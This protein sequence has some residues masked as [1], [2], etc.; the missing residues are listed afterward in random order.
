MGEQVEAIIRQINQEN[1]I[2]NKAR[3]MRYLIK[4]HQLRVI[5]LEKKLNLKSS[6]ICHLLRLNDLPPL[7]IDGYYSG[8]ISLSH[9]FVLSRLKDKK[10]LISL[11]EKVLSDNL[12]VVQTEEELREIIYQIKTKGE[13]LKKEKIEK[14]TNELKKIF[15]NLKIKLI[16]T[17]I[18]GKLI[19]EVK[20][21]LEGSS[22]VINWLIDK[23][24]K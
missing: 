13:Y 5:D 20:D 10:K 14:L 15:P 2:F 22:K 24:T 4:E 17:R 11:Y 7:V 23:L 16:Q 12:T 6:Y 21:N 19:F 8:L 9:L 18:K 3:L 1:D